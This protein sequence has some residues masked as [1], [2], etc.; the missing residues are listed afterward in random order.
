[1]NWPKPIYATWLVAVHSEANRERLFRF[2]FPERP[3]ALSRFLAAMRVDWNI[4]LFHYRSQGGDFG[5][6]LIGLEIPQS[7]SEHLNDFLNKLGYHFIE[8]TLDPAYKLFL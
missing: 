4:S 8:E 6:V 2:R 7:D 5:R 1:M 3:G